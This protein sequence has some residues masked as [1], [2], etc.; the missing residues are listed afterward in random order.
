MYKYYLSMNKKHWISVHFDKDVPDRTIEDLV[1][2]S[3]DLVAASLP[4]KERAALQTP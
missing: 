4:K 3:Y 2:Q 1:K